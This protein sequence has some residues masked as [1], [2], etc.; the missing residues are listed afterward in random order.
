MKK[1]K[2]KRKAKM[3]TVTLHLE[4]EHAAVLRELAEFAGTTVS[5]VAAVLIAAGAY[6]IRKQV[7]NIGK[8]IAPMT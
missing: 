8:E 1:K 6:T 3:N 5:I 4:R 7:A 2:T